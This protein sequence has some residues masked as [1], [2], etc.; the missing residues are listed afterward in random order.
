MMYPLRHSFSFY[1]SVFPCVFRIIWT[2]GGA[3]CGFVD[4]VLRSGFDVKKTQTQPNS[5]RA[6]IVFRLERVLVG[7]ERSAI[8][9]SH[10]RETE[11]P[12]ARLD[13]ATLDL[14]PAKSSKLFCA[15]PITNHK[16][17][18]S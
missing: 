2:R 10:K 7:E 14:L 15:K 11:G 17:K 9:S 13:L 16:S 4:Y 12:R 8:E 1:L 18:S 6:R 5:K 3:L